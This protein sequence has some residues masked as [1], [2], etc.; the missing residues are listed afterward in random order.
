LILQL[1]SK[2]NKKVIVL[3]DEYDKPLI[4]YLDPDNLHKAIDNRAIL[5]SFY[6]ILKDA[7][8]HLKLVFIT[9]ISKFS[10]VSIFSDLNNLYD[11]T[12]REDYNEICGISQ[13]ELEASFP[14]E[15]SV[16]DKEKIRH[17]YNGYRWH[18]RGEKVYNPFSLLNFFSG[19]GDFQNFWYT[20]G[21]PTFL[22]KMCLEQQLYELKRVEVS[23]IAL[24][25]FTVENLQLFPILFQTGYL[26]ITGYDDLLG[27]YQL[28]YPNKEVKSSYVEGLLEM[29][30][31]SREPMSRMVMGSL[32]RALKSAS[33][34]DLQEAINNTFAHIP[35][36]LWRKDGEHFYHA[37]IHLLFSLLGVYIQS[38]VHTKK[39]RADAVIQI[40]E[41][42]FI[43][44][45]KLNQTAEAAIAQIKNR[46]YADYFKQRDK[47]VHL[48]GINFSSTEKAVAK[49]IWERG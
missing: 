34:E 3:I 16:Y 2:Y 42:I 15:L 45:F 10:Q 28:D 23:Q 44:E 22:V 32:M 37:I 30:S 31:Y 7:D 19:D 5:K 39:G 40:E 49:L 26:T 13:R 43:F 41:G 4:D 9:G 29:Y 21:T 20:T 38:E 36:D 12:L 48:I 27:I 46:G 14:Q 17:W 18:L 8:P 33:L 47:P 24:N 6:S 11:I 25:S 1:S 35:Y